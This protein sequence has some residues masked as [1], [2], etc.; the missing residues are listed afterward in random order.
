MYVTVKEAAIKSGM[1]KSQIKDL[2]KLNQVSWKLKNG[3]YVVDLNSYIPKNIYDVFVKH[4][5]NTCYR[6]MREEMYDKIEN[7]SDDQFDYFYESLKLQEQS[8]SNELINKLEDVVLNENTYQILFESIENQI[9]SF[10]QKSKKDMSYYADVGELIVFELSQLYSHSMLS[11][12]PYFF[13]EKKLIDMIRN[14]QQLETSDTHKKDVVYLFYTA[15]IK[16]DVH[17]MVIET[18]ISILDY[19][20]YFEQYDHML[21]IDVSNIVRNIFALY[22]KKYFSSTRDM[23]LF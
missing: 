14:L 21:K 10:Y 2:I 19:E 5:T 3:S 18:V 20:Y 16:Q 23:F 4:C 13:N 6:D 7:A 12:Y 8:H 9:F 1:R 22:D 17:S 15:L 11:K